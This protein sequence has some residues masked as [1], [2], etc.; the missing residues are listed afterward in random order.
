M[1]H[2]PILAPAV[3]VCLLLAGCSSESVNAAVK[4]EKDRKKAPDFT[5]KD[6]DGRPVKLSDYKGRVV[7][8]NFWA[9]WCGPCRI[10]IPWFV[11]FEQK[12]KDRGFAVLGVAMDEDGWDVVKPYLERV[13]VNY[14]VVIGSDMVSEMYGGVE[15]FPTT[16]MLDREGRVASMHPGLMSRK[17]YQ[18]EIDQLLAEGAD[19]DHR[20]VAGVVPASVIAGAN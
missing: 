14:R 2:S 13:K 7:L 11:E 3:L 15:S 12:F 10:E 18:D 9:T 16:F 20:G 8:L 5:L 4:P 1:R 19:A 17:V 6:A